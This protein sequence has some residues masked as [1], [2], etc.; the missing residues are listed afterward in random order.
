[1]TDNVDMREKRKQQEAFLREYTRHLA[2]ELK[3]TIEEL[4]EI[5]LTCG[6]NQMLALWQIGRLIAGQ[7]NP[8]PCADPNSKPVY[9][10]EL[11]ADFL[12]VTERLLERAAEFFRTFPT[13]EEFQQLAAL[14]LSGG[15]P[16][17]WHH[18]DILL[19]FLPSTSAE[20]RRLFNSWLRKAIELGWAPETLKRAIRKALDP[21][22]RPVK[23]AADQPI[24][25][26]SFEKTRKRLESQAEYF[27]RNFQ[28]LYLSADSGVFATLR[29][30]P[31]RTIAEQRA[32]IQQ[33]LDKIR[34][35]S[36]QLTA[37]L[38]KLEEHCEAGQSH[39][40]HVCSQAQAADV[41]AQTAGRSDKTAA[42]LVRR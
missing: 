40:D 33:Q 10:Q 39:V 38:Q 17:L 3:S 26:L 34:Q 28:Q 42:T 41:R 1:M 4:W 12:G 15:R 32:P 21:R 16:L 22:T 18:V 23:R 24:E 19:Q 37:H 27:C 13:E 6:R 14:R 11:A 29:K 5:D 25:P 30:T 2:P 9:A 36:K 7:K 20:Q 31:A 35:L 8:G